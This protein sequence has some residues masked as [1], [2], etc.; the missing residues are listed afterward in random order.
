MKTYWMLLLG[1][2]WITACTAVIQPTPEQT[3]TPS[4]QPTQT[5]IAVRTPWWEHAVFYEIFVRSFY[6]SN[7]DGIGDF[8]GITQKLDYLQSLGDGDDRSGTAKFVAGDF[9]GLGT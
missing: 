7:G 4:P 8:N 1:C 5:S 3:A 6:D 2:L 9:G